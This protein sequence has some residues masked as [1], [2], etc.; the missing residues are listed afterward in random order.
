MSAPLFARATTALAVAFTAACSSPYK[1]ESA[2][3]PVP[4]SVDFDAV[5][6]TLDSH[7]GSLDCHG[8]PGRNFRLY[9][10]S[11]R[12]LDPKDVP[13]G[14]P[15]TPEGDDE[16]AEESEVP[17]HGCSVEEPQAEVST[18]PALPGDG[19]LFAGSSG[20]ELLQRKVC[21]PP[22]SLTRRPETQATRHWSPTLPFAK[23]VPP[24]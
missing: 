3:L 21:V 23:T 18:L 5:A 12:R 9:G 15:T 19:G 24:T 22:S 4:S 13:G 11:G 16:R 14:L 6:V 20:S 17:G 10:Y 1:G 7:C 2:T 8:K